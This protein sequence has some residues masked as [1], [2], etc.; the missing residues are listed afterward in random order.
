MLGSYHQASESF[1][2]MFNKDRFESLTPICRRSSQ[3]GVEAASSGNH[4]L[5]MNQYSTT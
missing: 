4:F 5:A 2:S 3:H 1:E